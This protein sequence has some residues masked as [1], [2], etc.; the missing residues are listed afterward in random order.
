MSSRV[1]VGAAATTSSTSPIRL[2]AAEICI[3]TSEDKVSSECEATAN[4]SL[5]SKFACGVTKN[6]G[7]GG[8]ARDCGGMT[9]GSIFESLRKPSVAFCF[10]FS[11]FGVTLT[12]ELV[13]GRS[14]GFG[15]IVSRGATTSTT[16]SLVR[17]STWV[18]IGVWR[19]RERGRWGDIRV[20]WLEDAW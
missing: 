9:M 13:E 11:V 12:T 5:P 7:D 18:S 6:V 16:S 15:G 2:S 10:S 4:I 17:G 19:E 20:V 3:G 14:L 8:E 1:G